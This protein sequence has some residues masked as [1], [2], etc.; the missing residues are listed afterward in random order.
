MSVHYKF[1]SSLDFDTVTFDGL[2]ISVADLKKSIM[3]QKKI[4]KS[5]DFDLQITNAQTKEVYDDD[6]TLVPK[7]TSVIVA[8]VPVLSTCK[9]V[10]ER[11]D[12]QVSTQDIDP[13]SHVRFDKLAK[14]A[15]LANAI[16]SEDEKIKAMMTQSS[17]EYD[18]SKYVKSRSMTGPLPPN[19]TCYRCGK[20]GHW[21]K[22]CPT[23]N[24]EIKR[25]TGIPRSFMVPVDGPEH[26][27]ALLTSTGE[28]AVPLIDHEAYK[29]V[30]KEKP[31]F[32]KEPEPEPDP[33][34]KLPEDLL[35]MVCRDLLQD[36]VL[37]P[38]CGDSFCDECVRQVLL[39]S[40]NHECPVCHETDI[41][42]DNLIPNRFLRTQ[43]MN[44]K[45][46][47]GYTRVKGGRSQP[48]ENLPIT[49]I[50]SPAV[51]P[52][53]LSPVNTIMVPPSPL[54]SQTPPTIQ[55]S[56]P[57]HIINENEASN[58]LQ[59]ECH[60]KI[61]E[62]ASVV[63]EEV[64]SESQI[65]H[66]PNNDTLEKHES[67]HIGIE[68]DDNQPGTP[69][70]DEPPVDLETELV[71][72]QKLS[73]DALQNT[74]DSPYVSSLP[75][76]GVCIE[77]QGD[78]SLSPRMDNI[79]GNTIMTI[80]TRGPKYMHSGFN[81]YSG[82][83]QNQHSRQYQS[84]SNS[85]RGPSHAET[86][87]HSI[88][89]DGE[90]KAS[91]SLQEQE[92]HLKQCSSNELDDNQPGTP[93]ADEPPVDLETELV[94]DQKLSTDAL[95]NTLDS[96]YVSS[97][98]IDGVCIE[99]Q[100]DNSL[101][102][103]MDNISGNTIMTITTRG[104]KYM[105]SGFNTYS[106]CLQNQHSRQ[107]QSRSNSSRGPSHGSSRTSR[108]SRNSYGTPPRERYRQARMERI[109][110]NSEPSNYKLSYKQS[111]GYA[112][113]NPSQSV[114]RNYQTQSAG[115]PQSLAS[116]SRYSQQIQTHRTNIPPEYVTQNIQRPHPPPPGLQ[117][118]YSVQP[119]PPGSSPLNMHGLSVPPSQPPPPGVGPIMLTGPPSHNSIYP[120]SHDAFYRETRRLKDRNRIG[121]PMDDFARELLEY[122]REQQ[123]RPH[124]RYHSR[125]RSSSSHSY[126]S[127]KSWPHSGSRSISH[128]CS[129]SRSRS[130]SSRSRSR[131]RLRSRS[132]SFSRSS[133][134]RSRSIS[135][136][137][138]RSRGRTSPHQRSRSNSP[139]NFVRYIPRSPYHQKK[140]YATNFYNPT[141][142]A[143]YTG[144]IPHH[145]IP[146]EHYADRSRYYRDQYRVYEEYH[147]PYNS[148]R[149]EQHDQRYDNKY[150][151]EYPRFD[152]IQHRARSRELEKS[153]RP[154]ISENTYRR[155]NASKSNTEKKIK[156]SESKE[157]ADNFA[158]NKKKDEKVKHKKHHHK[159]RENK[160]E[161]KHE[162]EHKKRELVD[163][164]NK[165]E[166]IDTQIKTVTETMEEQKAVP[167]HEVKE[168]KHKHK[169]KK[170][171][172][173]KKKKKVTH[174]PNE[175]EKPTKTKKK[176]AKKENEKTHQKSQSVEK[177]EKI[178]INEDLSN[179]VN[180]QNEIVLEENVSVPKESDVLKQKVNIEE[181]K[182]IALMKDVLPPLE[183]IIEEKPEIKPTFE[184]IEEPKIILMDNA[185][186][187]VYKNE[188]E[189]TVENTDE[190]VLSPEQIELS[191]R[192][193]EHRDVIPTVSEASAPEIS[194]ELPEISKWEREEFEEEEKSSNDD[195]N[196][197]QKEMRSSLSSDII[198]RAEKAILQKALKT[199]IVGPPVSREKHTYRGMDRKTEKS[200]RVA[201]AP[202]DTVLVVSSM[203]DKEKSKEQSIDKETKSKDKSEEASLQITI[204]AEKN[205][206]SVQ[207]TKVKSSSSKDKLSDNSQ[208]KKLKLDRSKFLEKS[209]NE[210]SLKH[211]INEGMTA[212]KVFSNDSSK[213]F[214]S[215]S[216]PRRKDKIIICKIEKD[217]RFNLEND[218]EKQSSHEEESDSRS[219]NVSSKKSPRRSKPADS[220]SFFTKRTYEH[221]DHKRE[222]SD[223]S[224]RESKSRESHVDHD[225]E[226]RSSHSKRVINLDEKIRR[227]E[228]VER[229]SSR[230]YKDNP[231]SYHRERE[232][233]REEP[234]NV[235][236]EKEE[237][238][239]SRSLDSGQS[240]DN[241]QLHSS[242][243]D[244]SD[245]RKKR[246]PKRRIS[247]HSSTAEI[248][249]KEKAVFSERMKAPKHSNID[250]RGFQEPHVRN[251]KESLHDE[252]KFE[253][254]YDET[255]ESEQSSDTEAKIR[256]SRH[257][258]E[259]SRKHVD[260]ILVT[261]TSDNEIE[262]EK[263]RQAAFRHELHRDKVEVK[264]RERSVS[265]QSSS[266][267]SP[268]SNFSDVDK[269]S[270]KRHKSETP[271]SDL[272]LRHRKSKHKKHKKH[273]RK[274]KKRKSHKYRER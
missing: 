2:H 247:S 177:S 82:C 204:S 256:R 135:R 255:S 170:D 33:E 105:H 127:S 222:I 128:S 233:Y 225:S 37:I 205:K 253:P 102:P 228:E 235:N 208:I 143:S 59:N 155:E 181:V 139:K 157:N 162:V 180:I 9:K 114:S 230:D 61:L 272:K 122:R 11:G 226:K 191:P 55:I 108:S 16:A 250:S 87:Q 50:Q 254:N 210:A 266:G 171:S 199:A 118:N 51:T 125:S 124:S 258:E 200:S 244:R 211:F 243:Q 190:K 92:E 273:K 36:A 227:K 52:V 187:N 223:S 207:T 89:F 56:S 31:P 198:Q 129:R 271:D 103:R 28:F 43:V 15:D 193:P 224:E 46:E 75:I 237:R 188:N 249:Q 30:K 265:P 132:R 25:S 48:V 45:N 110:R 248:K 62:E 261:R 72:D 54:Q 104:P 152:E 166:L 213:E 148:P 120:Y 1:K 126:N 20:P 60:E 169:K 220:N 153:E 183:Q 130:F 209:K 63:C 73:T 158:K 70:A 10:W 259:K 100:G 184:P 117:P 232:K 95:Q 185:D 83:L 197:L 192:E 140:D 260:Q 206:R 201:E 109:E 242:T 98:P 53:H 194:F 263:A 19:Y 176:K 17:Q 57:S 85:S 29:E 150:M 27:G 71:T 246:V 186:E 80:T 32:L 268:C 64:K 13:G 119:P 175:P 76:D 49:Q 137:R 144:S 4:G 111:Y 35:C 217:R 174:N 168:K 68:L 189:T 240:I 84:R 221:N 241:K 12:I 78:N 202:K 179:K 212:E 90:W 147:N 163:D 173:E 116:Q 121:D 113:Q 81:T 236:V 86:A 161:V 18:V 94:T 74:L 231:V 88:G 239:R 77:S 156:E 267:S 107:Y 219:R 264:K 79:S 40:E 182:P 38:C 24:L 136:S 215:K 138:S 5:A 245:D 58:S 39:D 99:S 96:P 44:F 123:H 270:A 151:H 214:S 101:S 196:S 69:L 112:Q 262:R 106:G 154:R 134:S 97:L 218:Q 47:T 14:T 22:N 251:R 274:H 131:S 34:P 6:E 133:H 172:E 141:Y 21:I 257:N 146:I 159:N 216:L 65:L 269:S 7:N 23:N 195:S 234:S 91:L 229:S 93:L 67:T 145:N 164:S 178:P 165:P 160:K 8:R 252:S 66:S 203:K 41:S 115:P 26:K 142:P 42:P 238:S 3:Q 149:Y 167:V